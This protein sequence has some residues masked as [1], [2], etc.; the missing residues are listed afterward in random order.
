MTEVPID[1]NQENI[2]LTQDELD[3]I[4]LIK[5]NIFSNIYI[6]TFCMLIYTL[7]LA[8]YVF[9]DLLPNK[10]LMFCLCL[11]VF[12]IMYYIVFWFMYQDY[13]MDM[14]KDIEVGKRKLETTILRR[15]IVNTYRY[16]LTFASQNIKEKDIILLV[17][18]S[19]YFRYR[20][21]TKVVIT[22]SRHTRQILSIDEL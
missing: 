15:D 12:S 17:D 5:K 11:L 13:A 20:Y 21:G 8:F 16:Y 6:M 4:C 2:P 9:Y 22:Y 1:Y 19:H 3:Y 18:K 10:F 7:P 14:E